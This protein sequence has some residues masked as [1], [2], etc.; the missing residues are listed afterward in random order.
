[1]Q[2]ISSYLTVLSFSAHNLNMRL[3]SSI[4]KVIEIEEK[5]LAISEH[6]EAVAIEVVSVEM[7][8]TGSH[9]KSKIGKVFHCATYK[10]PRSAN[11]CTCLCSYRKEH[12]ILAFVRKSKL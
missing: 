2:A 3:P 7:I 9:S 10:F 1:M 4:K 11:G 6:L 8:V 5:D 12:R